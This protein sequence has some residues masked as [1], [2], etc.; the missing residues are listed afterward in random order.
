[1]LPQL[2]N[3]VQSMCKFNQIEFAA[4]YRTSLLNSLRIYLHIL[5]VGLPVQSVADVYVQLHVIIHLVNILYQ[6]TYG[7]CSF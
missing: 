5:S 7:L 3:K 2:K 1:M 4:V 6:N